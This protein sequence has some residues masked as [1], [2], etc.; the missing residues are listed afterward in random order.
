MV[1][2]INDSVQEQQ[3]ATN[4]YDAQY[5]RSGMGVVTLVTKGGSNSFHGEFCDFFRNSLH[6]TRIYWANNEFDQPKGQLKRNQFGGN[7]SGPILKRYNLFFFAAYDG[8]RQHDTENSGLLTGPHRAGACRRFF[9]VAQYER[10]P[11]HD[12]ESVFDNTGYG[13][14]RQHL[15][16]AYAVSWQQNSVKPDQSHRRELRKPIPAAQPGEPRSKRL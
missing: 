11:T 15:L 13:C 10:R 7:I 3:V 12:L 1:S 4:V 2:P 16:H 5:E 8:L 9:T 14:R 6:S